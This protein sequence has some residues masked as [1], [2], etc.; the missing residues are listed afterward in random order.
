MR[1]SEW[2]GERKR[3]RERI[4]EREE[5]K[6]KEGSS[7]RYWVREATAEAAPPPQPQK[8]NN[9][10][11]ALNAPASLGSL[12]NRVCFSWFICLCYHSASL[13]SLNLLFTFFLL[14]PIGWNLGG[15]KSHQMGQWPIKGFFFLFF[16]SSL[17]FL[18]Q[19]LMSCVLE[20]VLAGAAGFSWFIAILFW[21]SWDYRC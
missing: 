12:W 10:D 4:M 13:H 11:V 21:K 18:L 5:E 17:Y 19:S 8:L 9:N 14:F 2:G 16:H 15:E 7:Y 20:I 3:E 6:K 1:R